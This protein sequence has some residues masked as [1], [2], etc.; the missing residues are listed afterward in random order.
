[1]FYLFLSQA[2]I[3]H[4][5]LKL[6][7]SDRMLFSVSYK[8]NLLQILTIMGFNKHVLSNSVC[9]VSMCTRHVKVKKVPTLPLKYDKTK[10]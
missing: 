6:N 4:E 2:Q 5:H 10:W 9:E 7:I 8:W 3:L 1:M